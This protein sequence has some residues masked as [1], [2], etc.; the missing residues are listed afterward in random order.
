V[1]DEWL[2][3][4]GLSFI[5]GKQAGISVFDRFQISELRTAGLFLA[6]P[7][8]YLDLGGRITT[9]G[10]ADYRI[11]Q[12][13]G[14]F[15]KK[16]RPEVSLG[17]QVNYRHIRSRWEDVP[18]SSVSAAL[19]V[20]YQLNAQTD[21]ALLGENLFDALDKKGARGLVGLSYR[22]GA[23]VSLFLEGA[24]ERENRASFA[25]GVAYAL[26]ETIHVR[27]GYDSAR[28]MPT[29]GAGYEWNRWQ[30]DAGFSLH[31]V[32]GINSMIGIKYRL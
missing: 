19:G 28:G 9:Y 12:W 11:T 17:L 23:A 7:N 32:L 5:K 8:R 21:L 4:A 15:A 27:S 3:P 2:N 13:Q 24:C 1:G 6:Y 18:Q 31:P 10:F 29:L 26:S 20:H 30:L 25:L 14:S 22:M 16:I